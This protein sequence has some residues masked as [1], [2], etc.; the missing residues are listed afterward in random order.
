MYVWILAVSSPST[1]KVPRAI[2][3]L[4]VAPPRLSILKVVHVTTEPPRYTVPIPVD[5]SPIPKLVP[6]ET[7]PP[8]KKAVPVPAKPT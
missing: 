4:A 7:V 8:S 6:T 2:S 5:L 3:I 1:I